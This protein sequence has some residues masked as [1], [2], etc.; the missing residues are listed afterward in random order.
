MATAEVVSKNVLPSLLWPETLR[1]T[2]LKIR[3]LRRA[4]LAVIM[5]DTLLADT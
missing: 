1:G 5:L 3:V 2:V 4:S